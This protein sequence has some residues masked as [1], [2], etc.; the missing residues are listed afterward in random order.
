M[1]RMINGEHFDIEY[2]ETEIESTLLWESHC[3]AKYE[4]ITVLEGDISVMLEGIDYR[5]KAGQ[6][7][8]IP[9]LCYHT[10]IANSHGEYRRITVLFDLNAV[11]APLRRYFSGK[12]MQLTVFLSRISSE[13]KEICRKS[14]AEYYAPLA[15][16]L[17]VRM[18]YEY[19]EAEH[20]PTGAEID[21]EIAM[22]L[23]YIDEHLTEKIYLD[24]LA[25]HAACS[26]STLCHLFGDKMKISPK[27][28]ILRKKL[29]LADKMIREGE[30][31]TIAAIRIGYD[32][33]SDFYRVYR[34]LYKRSPKQ[35]QK[36]N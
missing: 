16:S 6:T 11:P 26:K 15:E 35:T 25:A 23:K 34:A 30:S 28:Y 36:N 18:L 33:Y 3:H 20:A 4:I 13:L 1:N 9:P 24:E 27:Q 14:S 10:I 17:I 5:I 31:P 7:A 32:N 12:D 8:I 21:K 2:K 29:A 19:A 22:M